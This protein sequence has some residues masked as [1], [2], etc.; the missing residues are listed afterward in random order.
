MFEDNAQRG[1]AAIPKKAGDT[2]GESVGQKKSTLTKVKE[3]LAQQREVG[4]TKLEENLAKDGDNLKAGDLNNQLTSNAGVP[5]E[6]NL[7]NLN[8]GFQDGWN[9]SLPNGRSLEQG[10]TIVKDRNGVLS[11]AYQR[12][13]T[14]DGT[15]VRVLDKAP[16]GYQ[17]YGTFHTHPYGEND[18]LLAGMTGETFSG[19]DIGCKLNNPNEIISVV[20]SGD[21]QF[22]LAKTP[23]TYNKPVDID[24]IDY[25][26]H[27][28]QMQSF[29][30]KIGTVSN[31]TVDDVQNA[32]KEST[33]E[34]T[35]KY[36]KRFGL[37]YYEGTDSLFKLVE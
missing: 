10:A 2:T 26:F 8:S 12:G 1:Y 11:L 27:S 33:R 23:V 36:A 25:S 17:Q 19:A 4:N 9:K 14:A 21:Q 13:G 20:Q 34:T 29:Y 31:P 24:Q 18:D 15:G 30:K 22:L 37:A 32:F 7:K 6:I 5:K 35:I 3:K 16:G 28:E